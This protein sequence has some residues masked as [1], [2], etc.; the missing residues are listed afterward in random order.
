M[1][2]LTIP[3]E[4]TSKQQIQNKKSYFFPKPTYAMEERHRMCCK[5]ARGSKNN[6]VT[7]KKLRRVLLNTEF[8][9]KK[10]LSNTPVRFSLGMGSCSAGI[11]W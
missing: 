9:Q 1:L 2:V 8:L 3:G 5:I 11:G 4:N 10:T 6:G 7:T